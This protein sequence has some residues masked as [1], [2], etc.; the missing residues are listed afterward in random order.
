[1]VD[2]LANGRG[3]IAATLISVSVI[4]GG[5]ITFYGQVEAMN[6]RLDSLESR[7]QTDEVMW[8]SKLDSLDSLPRIRLLGAVRMELALLAVGG[9][10]H[11]L[12]PG[13]GTVAGSGQWPRRNA[14]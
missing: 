2:A 9:G 11:C 8:N 13:C 10:V 3:Y 12:V 14:V 1:M 4:L 7:L 6:Q 5:I